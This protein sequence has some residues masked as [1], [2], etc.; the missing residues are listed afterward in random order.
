MDARGIGQGKMR[1]GLTLKV[2][3]PNVSLDSAFLV[4]EFRG[5]ALQR[6][7]LGESVRTYVCSADFLQSRPTLART[8]AALLARA[9]IQFC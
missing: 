2:R 6:R 8:R 9:Y 7:E 1:R 5:R 3:R 4:F